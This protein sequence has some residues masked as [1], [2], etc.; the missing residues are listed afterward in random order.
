M[1]GRNSIKII[2]PYAQGTL[3]NLGFQMI[4]ASPRYIR[5]IYHRMFPCKSQALMKKNFNHSY[6]NKTTSMSDCIP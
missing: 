1:I 2:L 5:N 4:P 6:Q 3:M